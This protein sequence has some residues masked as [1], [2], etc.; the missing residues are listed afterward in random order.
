MTIPRHTDTIIAGFANALLLTASTVLFAQLYQMSDFPYFASWFFV[1]G[2]ALLAVTAIFV[3]GH[4]SA[5]GTVLASIAAFAVALTFLVPRQYDVA[6]DE[7]QWLSAAKNLLDHSQFLD[8]S[9]NFNIYRVGYVLL[10]ALGYALFGIP[11]A[12]LVPFLSLAIFIA[13]LLA[14]S[15]RLF[16]LPTAIVGTALFTLT[17]RQHYVTSQLIDGACSA[18]VMAMFLLM[19]SRDKRRDIWRGML[20]GFACFV[21]ISIKEAAIVVVAFPV[22]CFVVGGSFGGRSRIAGFYLVVLP[23]LSVY[24][25]LQIFLN[26][27]IDPY[28][29]SDDLSFQQFAF[30]PASDSFLSSVVRAVGNAATGLGSFVFNPSHFSSLFNFMGIVVLLPLALLLSAIAAYRGGRE[31]RA[32]LA[33]ITL[34]IPVM[35]AAGWLDWRP[36]QALPAVA[37]FYVLIAR[38]LTFFSL[39]MR[40]PHASFVSGFLLLAL[41]LLFQDTRSGFGYYRDFENS[42]LSLLIH[43]RSP[44]FEVKFKGNP[45]LWRRFTS[46]SATATRIWSSPVLPAVSSAL[47]SDVR[48]WIAPVPF[49]VLGMPG[50]VSGYVKQGSTTIRGRIWGVYAVAPASPRA[51]L[52]LIYRDDLEK[53]R[54]NAELILLTSGDWPWL[55]PLR[56]MLE[57]TLMTLSEQIS[58]TDFG[59]VQFLRWSFNSYDVNIERQFVHR[60]ALRHLEYLRN[61]NPDAFRWYMTRLTE[62]GLN[63]PVEQLNLTDSW[64][65]DGRLRVI[66]PGVP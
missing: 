44:R 7:A 64:P 65:S 61:M 32:L 47:A 2:L 56:A 18:M 42:Q 40:W 35:S 15:W 31:D 39:S 60:D 33:M 63:I 4:S 10:Y 5:S 8:L 13:L 37:F 58:T 1:F 55:A 3:L 22:L 66:T 50:L 59:I 43:G 57:P 48:V 30:W 36:E 16:G 14:A 25:I 17:P 27:P 41:A 49:H 9:G 34:Y 52:Y 11:G 29:R 26:V 46:E 23:L 62:G 12:A 28:F 6:L 21:A 24:V 54:R 19:V 20:G 38:L 51:P 45:E 53:G